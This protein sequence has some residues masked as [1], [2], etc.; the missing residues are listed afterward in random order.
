MSDN[1]PAAAV[2][3][4]GRRLRE[5]DDGDD[6]TPLARR[7]RVVNNNHPRLVPGNRFF[8]YANMF[9]PI[10]DRL[11][12]QA[13]AATIQTTPF[14]LWRQVSILADDK[15]VNV[16]DQRFA[17]VRKTFSSFYDAVNERI[18]PSET[19]QVFLSNFINSAAQAIYGRD[20]DANAN[21]L[22][23]RNGWDEF[24]QEVFVIA[25]RA[26]GKTFAL[27]IFFASLLI[28]CPGIKTAIFGHSM[29]GTKYVVKLIHQ[30]LLSHKKGKEMIVHASS[31]SITLRGPGGDT[32]ER[33]CIALPNTE[34]TTRGTQ[35]DVIGV[36]ELAFISEQLLMGTLLPMLAKKRTCIIGISTPMG[37]DNILTWLIRLMDASKGVP[38]PLFNV[39][40]A[41][42]VCPACVE[43]ERAFDCTHMRFS[44]PP[45]KSKT[46]MARM[47]IVYAE[48]PELLVRE[49]LGG[50]ANSEHKAYLP[51]EIDAFFKNVS[52]DVTNVKCVYL[53]VDPSG[54][55]PSEFAAVA[56]VEDGQRLSVRYTHTL[57]HFRIAILR[58][59][60]LKIRG[61][62]HVARRQNR[63]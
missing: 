60:P 22:L 40:Q 41:G 27:G 50:V 55:G 48:R 12:K 46:K 32:D 56:A 36:D 25:A 45:W 28:H 20:F 49:V 5:P 7:F 63:K 39:V 43:A 18:K 14:P 23:E 42:R 9:L 31:E 10:L 13:Q 38:R 61:L 53:A 57:T 30:L 16:G 6:C 35:V 51:S 4:A 1:V 21:K 59:A 34:N 33:T 62:R 44:V 52:H 47:N 29:R 17:A 26:D 24:R 8:P 2:F 15:L 54:G 11:S 3:A 19:Q 37:D 58:E